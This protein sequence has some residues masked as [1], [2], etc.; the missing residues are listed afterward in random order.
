MPSFLCETSHKCCQP[1][2]ICFVS[3]CLWPQLN[4]CHAQVVPH[5]TISVTGSDMNAYPNLQ[6]THPVN[7]VE[8]KEHCDEDVELN[9]LYLHMSVAASDFKIAWLCKVMKVCI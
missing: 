2:P 3:L 1:S 9:H 7:L 8:F 4:Y 5:T 6:E